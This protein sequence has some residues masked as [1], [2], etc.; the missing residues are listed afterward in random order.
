MQK[1]ESEPAI[2]FHAFNR[3]CDNLRPAVADAARLAWKE[4]GRTGYPFID[5]CMRSLCSRGWINF[6]MQAML[7]SFASYTFGWTGALSRI[8]WPVS[9]LIMNPA[10]IIRRYKCKA[11]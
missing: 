10:F 7:V 8:G 5:A 9:L 1:L 6:R 4:K 3:A 2:E 11:G